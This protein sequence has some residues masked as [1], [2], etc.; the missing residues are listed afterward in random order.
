M[1]NTGVER[2]RSKRSNAAAAAAM[3]PPGRERA[4]ETEEEDDIDESR[5]GE[6]NK[7]GKKK[8][9][10]TAAYSHATEEDKIL[11][12]NLIEELDPKNVSCLGIAMI[13]TPF[14]CTNQTTIS[15][16]L[17]RGA[18]TRSRG[19]RGKK[20]GTWCWTSSTGDGQSRTRWRG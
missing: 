4:S 8:T 7:K 2:E 20:S 17:A 11:L 9:T 19:R 3:P 15:S 5:R 10:T 16:T 18:A 1:L 14:Y 12:F 13:F 6:K